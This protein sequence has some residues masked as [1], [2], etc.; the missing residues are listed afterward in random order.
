MRELRSPDAL[1]FFSHPAHV[2]QE[3]NTEKNPKLSTSRGL[4]PSVLPSEEIANSYST[5]KKKQPKLIELVYKLYRRSAKN[6]RD[7]TDLRRGNT[8]IIAAKVSPTPTRRI[9]DGVYII[10]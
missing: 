8:T 7:P 6:I 5:E 10:R 2:S 1:F 4:P 9:L 3:M